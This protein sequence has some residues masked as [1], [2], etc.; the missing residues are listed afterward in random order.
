MAIRELRFQRRWITACT[1][2]SA[3]L[4][5]GGSAIA[6]EPLFESKPITTEKFTRHIEGPA[7]DAEGN[8]F[9]PNF[10]VDGTIGKLPTGATEF[11]GFTTLDPP[12]PPLPANRRIG[13]GIRFD[14]QGRMYI[15]DFNQHN[16]LVIEPGERKANPYL[17]PGPPNRFNQPNDL[18]IAADGT[19]YAS[20][21]QR[22]PAPGTGRIWRIRRGP[23]GKG[24]GEVM[25]TTRPGKMG[26]TNGLD[27]SPDGKTLYVSE[28]S[29]RQVWSYRL[30]GN[31]LADH[32]LV[33]QFEISDESDVDGLRTDVDGRIFLARPA[34]GKITII[35]IIPGKAGKPGRTLLREVATIGIGPT[36]LSF[37]GPDGKTVLVTQTDG[38]LVEAFRTD[39]PGREPCLQAPA[40]C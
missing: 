35:T 8:L 13:S 33:K 2:A 32:K 6:Q 30:D 7:V 15:A 28:S 4:F 26:T 9:V 14:R 36:N 24:R 31:R 3:C 39:R 29:T 20:D 38:M 25:T 19:L 17:S 12:P 5:A 22:K 34:A 1:I 27:L 40:K 37:G 18:A 23:D 21:P 10:G 16:V 11:E